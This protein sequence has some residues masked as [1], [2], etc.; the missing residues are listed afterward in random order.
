MYKKADHRLTTEK[1]DGKKPLGWYTNRWAGP[2]VAAKTRNLLNAWTLKALETLHNEHPIGYLNSHVQFKFWKCF[3]LATKA[4]THTKF[5]AGA[6]HYGE[7][8]KDSPAA[9]PFECPVRS[10]ATTH[11]TVWAIL[12]QDSH[13]CRYFYSAWKTAVHSVKLFFYERHLKIT[14]TVD[15]GHNHMVCAENKYYAIP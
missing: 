15:L 4:R 13:N 11:Y 8:N 14:A 1:Y 5:P 6:G 12:L 2:S 7:S 9:P 10:L 3:F